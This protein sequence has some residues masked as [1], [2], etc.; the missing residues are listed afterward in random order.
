[1]LQTN[2]KHCKRVKEGGAILERVKKEDLF[3]NV[4]FEQIAKG[5]TV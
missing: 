1:M 3:D 2:T 5:V 4:T